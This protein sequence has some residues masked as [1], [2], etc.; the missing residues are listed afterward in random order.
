MEKRLPE[1][2]DEVVHSKSGGEEYVEIRAS[3][4]KRDWLAPQIVRV[5]DCYYRLEESWVGKGERPFCY[6]LRKLEAGVMGSRV[7]VYREERK[8]ESGK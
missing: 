7:I 5:E 6:R 8:T 1:V 3:R 4:K 2:A